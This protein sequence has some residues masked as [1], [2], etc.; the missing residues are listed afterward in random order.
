MKAHALFFLLVQS[1]L[2]FHFP[3]G[4][5]F[6]SEP[7]SSKAVRAESDSTYRQALQYAPIL[8][9]AEKE[10]YFPTIPFFSAFDT[11][12]NDG[13]GIR[14][15]QDPQE[16]APLDPEFTDDYTGISWNILDKWYYDN[17]KRDILKTRI[18]VF[19][20]IDSVKAQDLY[21]IIRS[22]EQYWH[23]YGEKFELKFSGFCTVYEYYFYYIRDKGLQGHPEDIE[24]VFVFVPR[25]PENT[26]RI[27]VGA[28]HHD[29]IPNNV[30]IYDKSDLEKLKY[31]SH[32]PIL[33]ELGGHSSAPDINNNGL[34]NPGIDA[35][36]HIEYLWGSRDI[37]AVSGSGAVGKYET[38][39][40][41]SRDT[42][43]RVY[44]PDTSC[45]KFGSERLY[46]LIP[47][48]R[49]EDMDQFY[50]LYDALERISASF[51]ITP[52]GRKKQLE[53]ARA[54][55]TVDDAQNNALVNLVREVYAKP[56]VDEGQ[57]KMLAYMP[58]DTDLLKIQNKNPDRF[59]LWTRYM[60]QRQKF[61][62]WL[63][64]G[65]NVWGRIGGQAMNECRIECLLP[66]KTM[67][68]LAIPSGMLSLEAGL[69]RQASSD[70]P[71]SPMKNEWTAGIRCSYFYRLMWHTGLSWVNRRPNA[72]DLNFNVG[73]SIPVAYV[74]PCLNSGF[75]YN[76]LWMR[77]DANLDA[78]KLK[79]SSWDLRLGL[80]WPW[81]VSYNYKPIHPDKHKIWKHPNY[82]HSP[83]YILKP[84][85]Y[86][87][88][89][90]GAFGLFMHHSFDNV[91]K[92]EIRF[93]W[94]A[95]AMDWLPLK[96]NGIFELQLGKILER[97]Y[98]KKISKSSF[99]NKGWTF[100]AYYDRIYAGL[101]SWY[102]QFTYANLRSEIP[103]YKYYAGGGLTLTPWLISRNSTLIRYLRIRTGVRYI[104][105]ETSY[106]LT[107]PHAEVQF[108]VHY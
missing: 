14:D 13:N 57:K 107:N 74:C 94:I 86:R 12:D 31:G 96:I 106:Q 90:R 48:K 26:C 72:S 61:K 9:F 4:I 28:G 79:S 78:V 20:K 24:Q 43:D 100:A 68:A 8:W 1:F 85:L 32:M 21:R 38:W 19:Y 52:P 83:E 7:N 42:F 50:G 97:G 29:N 92:P 89:E 71:D 99:P 5:L 98:L 60:V 34:F 64:W 84:H 15:L 81:M 76:N 47:V 80:H 11:T 46:T 39:M 105:D 62:K 44:P 35:N 82:T 23:R 103:R 17:N 41:F 22:D 58:P 6:G 33:V 59:L 87:P 16:I 27:V 49:F 108:G 54:R 69:R 95:P 104:I 51:E 55:L 3:S 56:A 67:R 101:F 40:T 70:S 45:F 10:E 102:I 63:P 30:L 73:F 75:F 91:V 18:F 36:W 25:D 53:E 66:P 2:S 88:R 37:Q 65:L 93:S 77:V